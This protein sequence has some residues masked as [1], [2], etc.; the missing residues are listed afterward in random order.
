MINVFNLRGNC[1]T[2][3]ELRRKEG[4]NVFGLG[5]R[6]PISITL[7]VKKPGNNAPAKIQ[8]RDIGDYFNQVEKL[9]KVKDLASLL[10][11]EMQLSSITPNED[12]DWLNQ[13]DGLFDTFIP[14]A[15]E[16]KYDSSS[17]SFFILNTRG[18]ETSRDSIAYNSSREMLAQNICNMIEG[19]NAQRIAFQEAQRNGKIKVEDFVEDATKKIIWTRGTKND[20][21]RNI[22]YSYD[23]KKCRIAMYRP[24]FK[25]FAYFSPQ[26]NEYVNQWPQIFPTPQTKNLVICVPG[27]GVT[28]DFSVFITD[29]IPDLELIGKSQCFPLYYFEEVQTDELNLYDNAESQ[30]IRH[31]GITDFALSRAR[32]LNP[33]ITREDVFYYVYGFLHNQ[34]YRKRFSSDL[35]KSLPHI[36]FPNGYPVFKAYCKAGRDLAALHLNYETGPFCKTVIVSG[37]E[38]GKYHVQKM[39]FISKDDKRTIIFNE[40]IKIE[41]VPLVAYDYVINGKSAIEWVMERYAVTTNADSGILN[42]PNQW[43]ENPRYILDLLLRVIQMSVDTVQIV[44][45]LPEMNFPG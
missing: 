32:E 40:F 11:P 36:P 15:A 20:L 13:R 44:T 22:Q 23:D 7:L 17:M 25:Q 28:K 43:S 27:V 18:L 41:N 6:T 35:K 45:K 33:K 4:G 1:R 14:V 30:F 5:S 19:Y 39:R 3:G 10:S 24:F 37:S 42:D 21:A 29:I 9:Q 16:K 8:Y 12:N 38:R 34:A 31:D 2:S 26:C